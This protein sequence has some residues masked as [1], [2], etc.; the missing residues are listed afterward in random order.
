MISKSVQLPCE[1]T[2]VLASAESGLKAIKPFLLFPMSGSDLAH[3]HLRFE[4][5]SLS[6]AVLIKIK[7]LFII[8]LR[9]DNK[10]RL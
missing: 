3:E 4:A 2:A 9:G 6:L 7:K 8:F 5:H 10:F 1:A